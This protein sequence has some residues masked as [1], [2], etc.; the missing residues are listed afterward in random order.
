MTLGSSATTPSKMNTASTRAKRR[1]MAGFW[2]RYCSVF[3]CQA[4]N[5]EGEKAGGA[6]LA[7]EWLQDGRQRVAL[8]WLVLVERSIREIITCVLVQTTPLPPLRSFG[9]SLRDIAS[10]S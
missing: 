1:R 7:L 2:R 6:V 10:S 4:H 8:H 3:D 9:N 5:G